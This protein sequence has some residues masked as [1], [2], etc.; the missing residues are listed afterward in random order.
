MRGTCACLAALAWA[1]VWAT[2]AMA[3]P[4]EPPPTTQPE[5]PPTHAELYK[6]ASAAAIRTVELRTAAGGALSDGDKAAIEKS[7]AELEEAAKL[8]RNGDFAAAAE[9]AAEVASQRRAVLG[10]EHHLTITAVVE[11]RTLSGF[12]SASEADRKRLKQADEDLA[13]AEQALLDG[14]SAAAV[15][16]ARK[17]LATREKILGK[18]HVEVGWAAK[19]LGAALID[20]QDYAGA[21][22]ALNQA[23]KI[24]EAVYGKRHPRTAI[25]LDRLGWLGIRQA[26]AKGF[27]RTLV[28]QAAE[29]LRRGLAILQTTVGETR[30]TA[31][32]QDNLGT[33]QLYTREPQRALENKL[34]AL[35]VRQTVLGPDDRDTA[36][37]LS[38]LAW[39]YEQLGYR[40]EVIPLR[41]KALAVLE[42]AVGH[43]HPY[44]VAELLNLSS[45]YHRWDQPAEAVRLLEQYLAKGEPRPE[46]LDPSI[47]EAVATLAVSYLETD[48]REE[49]A[50]AV[51]KAFQM[52]K[53][54]HAAGR[55]PA[56]AAAAERIATLFQQQRMLEDALSA[57][58]QLREW[59]GKKEATDAFVARRNMQL[60]AILT[61][62]GRL[63]E[64]RQIL[65][66]VLRD[67]VKLHGDGT[68]ETFTPLLMLS[69]TYEKLGDLDKAAEY[70]DK[71]LRI[72]ERRLPP[73]SLPVG[74]AMQALGRIKIAKK[75]LDEARFFLEDAQ[76][77]YEKFES[78]TPALAASLL[79]EL[80]ALKEAEGQQSEAAQ[81][82][83]DAVDKARKIVEKIPGPQADALLAK[84]L[85][86]LADAEPSKAASLKAELKTVLERLQ[87]RRGLDAET[88]AWLKELGGGGK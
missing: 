47:V 50:A 5:G 68:L 24:I 59:Q 16:A 34:R 86:L 85:K 75:E 66:E 84:S 7:E 43:D 17:A 77:V 44:T 46:R 79:F 48:R 3:Q 37:S 29:H 80:A 11:S 82:L 74:H 14:D 78:Q 57:Y 19:V 88:A 35:Y 9:K 18:D 25:V 28:S 71:A 83:R 51:A 49:A 36:V 61:D 69:R 56:A 13:Q 62:L 58:E 54:L 2:A 20:E 10:N 32:T 22:T 39:L 23:L 55:K 70:G 81:L 41:Q 64:S 42:K 31:E 26:G 30:E 12:A 27:E 63:E 60:G 40:D 8:R 1:A 53:A 72:A 65:D 52:A 33:V 67:Y 73:D 4:G 76:R 45:L 87:A 21:E 6:R 15:A 38:N